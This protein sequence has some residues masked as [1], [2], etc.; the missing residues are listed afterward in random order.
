MMCKNTSKKKQ[1]EIIKVTFF[2]PKLYL[3]NDKLCTL[4]EHTKKT[5][6]KYI[7]YSQHCSKHSIIPY[8][9]L[10]CLYIQ[11]PHPLTNTLRPL[12]SPP[13]HPGLPATLSSNF[14]YSIII[15]SYTI[16]TIKLLYF[17]FGFIL[18]VF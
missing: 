14:E 6:I 12:P 5:E 2:P 15:L 8:N 3:F 16:S 1:E 10:F 13:T 4:I 9:T 11:P 17:I 7:E 18:K